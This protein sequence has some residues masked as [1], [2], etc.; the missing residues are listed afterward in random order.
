[1]SISNS[2]NQKIL[3]GLKQEGVS[4]PDQI[5]EI[6]EC[7]KKILSTIV[8]PTASFMEVK[9]SCILMEYGSILGILCFNYFFPNQS[10]ELMKKGLYIFKIGGNIMKSLLKK[11]EKMVMCGYKINTQDNKC[12]RHV[13]GNYTTMWFF[14]HYNCK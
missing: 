13:K 6:Y 8:H 3:N 9:T 1:L 14:I 7:T 11:S 4:I 10:T 5:L 12:N 2:F